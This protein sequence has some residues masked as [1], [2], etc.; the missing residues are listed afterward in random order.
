MKA[1]SG[2]RVFAILV[3]V[4]LA[5]IFFNPQN[6]PQ[7]KAESWVGVPDRVYGDGYLY[8]LLTKNIVE[9]GRLHVV[10]NTSMLYDATGLSLGVGDRVYVTPSPAISFLAA[11]F[12]AL[13]GFFGYY[14]MNALLGLLTCYVIYRMCCLYAT[15]PVAARTTLYFGVGTMT[16]TYSQVFYS[17]ILSAALAAGAYYL[18]LK[19]VKVGSSWRIIYAGALAGVM[20]L[21][22][23]TLLIMVA[24]YGAYILHETRRLLPLY[25]LGFLLTAWTY[26]A[27]NTLCFGGPLE[28]GYGSQ[29]RIVDGEIETVDLNSPG[30]WGK[31]PLVSAPAL[32]IVL[33]TTNPVLLVSIAGLTKERRS[34]FNV[35]VA[36]FLLLALAYGMRYDSVGG[37]SWSWRFMLPLVPLAALPAAVAHGRYVD[38]KTVKLLFM[39]SAYMTLLS[40]APIA[41]HIMSGTPLVQAAQASVI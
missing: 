1:L 4:Y 31:N 16:L 25:V 38:G 3:V 11:P 5:L 6:A 13:L 12:Y 14:L 28:T 32:T 35:L 36:C 21:T 22:R 41:W 18:M 10:E 29:L 24:V 39:I 8:H 40:L 26:P 30:R 27:Y 33:L 34:E 9:E 37:W 2:R 20:P 15:E 7:K 17:D 19:G 23:P